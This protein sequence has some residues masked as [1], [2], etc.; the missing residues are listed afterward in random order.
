MVGIAAASYA[1][2]LTNSSL[3]LA[4]SSEIW[5]GDIGAYLQ[6]WEGGR[7]GV[8]E[9]GLL[10]VQEGGRRQHQEAAAPTITAT[11]R[12]NS[13]A[14]QVHGTAQRVLLNKRLGADAVQRGKWQ[15]D[16]CGRPPSE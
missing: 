7:G 9:V 3:L 8:G 15:E 6:E 10:L 13:Q 4:F 12:H 16:G 5:E 14:P 1:P 2:P 11:A